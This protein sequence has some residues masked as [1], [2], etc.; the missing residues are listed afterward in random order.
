MGTRTGRR[1]RTETPGSLD[2]SVLQR[3][4]LVHFGTSSHLFNDAI[5]ADRPQFRKISP[6]KVRNP[7]LVRFL[8]ALPL[9]APLP[10][11]TIHSVYS[12]S[13]HFRL[14]FGV[15][16]DLNQ[17]EGG[18]G[19]RAPRGSCAA[20]CEVSAATVARGPGTPAS[21]PVLSILPQ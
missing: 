7:R 10:R 12:R 16:T 19:E 3:H 15:D 11:D 20:S 6:G 1:D 2:R 9:V 17:M 14:I 21:P 13:Q 8:F 18:G 5:G 4:P